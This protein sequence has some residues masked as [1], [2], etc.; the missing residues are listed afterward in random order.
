MILY[1]F[2]YFELIVQ[3]VLIYKRCLYLFQ[4]K[5]SRII[6]QT[7]KGKS[8]INTRLLYWKLLSLMPHS[9]L[10]LTALATFTHGSDHPVLL[11][12]YLSQDHLTDLCI[13]WPLANT[14]WVWSILLW[15]FLQR[16]WKRREKEARRVKNQP[17]NIPRAEI[18]SNS[19]CLVWDLFQFF[20]LMILGNGWASSIPLECWLRF[21]NLCKSFILMFYVRMSK[22]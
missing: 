15:S 7:L 11:F 4:F 17:T 20:I 1:W 10:S 12:S 6:L 19:M 14:P 3:F 8:I 2:D 5:F 16:L 18:Y 22:L 21:F 13:R 9:P